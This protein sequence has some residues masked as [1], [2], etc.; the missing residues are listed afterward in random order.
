VL[1]R[2]RALAAALE[3]ELD[4]FGL[5]AFSVDSLLEA[6]ACASHRGVSAVVLDGDGFRATLR[7]TLAAARSIVS[8]P[9]VLLSSASGEEQQ[10]EALDAGAND[11]LLKPLS[12]RLVAAKLRRLLAIV[13]E[14]RAH[15]APVIAV[16]RLR[17]DRE[18]EL[19]SLGDSPLPLTSGE[20]GLLLGLASQPGV[21]VR[22]EV[23]WQHLDLDGEGVADRAGGRGADMHVCRLRRKLHDAGADEVCIDTIYGK[24]YRLSLIP[25]ALVDAPAGRTPPFEPT[26]AVP[27]RA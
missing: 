11:V 6:S 15:A 9:V 17:L 24:G 12:P 19:A 18:R 20:F 7:P 8:G 10:I 13:G 4:R 22:R 2:D 21:I 14:S 25:R 26:H 3:L 1:A 23:L 27:G 16:G 5:S